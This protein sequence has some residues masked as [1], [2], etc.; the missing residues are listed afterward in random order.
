MARL[1]AA[2]LGYGRSGSTMHAGAYE[3]NPDAFELAA[4]CDIDPERRRQAQERF[5]C[6]VYADY[7][8]MLAQERLDLVSVITRS[9]QHAAMTCACLDAGV[10]VLVTKPWAVNAA[11]AEGMIAAAQRNGRQLLPWLPARWGCVFTRLRALLAQG[12][13]GEVF[14]IR[15]AECTF[16]TR[17]DWQ[18]EKRYGGG[19]LL[20]WGPHVV[21]P[22]ILLGG[23]RPATV[24]GRLRQTINPGDVEDVVFAVITLANG[25]IVQSEYT[26]STITTPSWFIQGTRGTIEVRDS[27]IRIVSETPARP[28]DP[29]QYADTNASEESTTEERVAGALYGDEVAIYA[30]IAQALRGQKP[31][32]VTTAHALELSRV[33]DAVRTSHLEDRLVRL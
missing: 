23:G 5:G 8:Q 22:P 25:V 24:F 15:R 13:I 7:R 20:N 18:T 11:T 28:S 2:V 14:L 3:G 32:P 29:T 21:D 12:V 6:A 33:F 19:Y 31:Y 16:A 4:V 17:C 10:N 30:E 1:R 27:T 9:D 26:I